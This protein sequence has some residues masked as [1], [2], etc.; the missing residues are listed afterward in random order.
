MQCVHSRAWS[1]VRIKGSTLAAKRGE[2]AKSSN[3]TIF[4]Q[5]ALVLVLQLAGTARRCWRVAL[6]SDL[7]ILCSRAQAQRARAGVPA[8]V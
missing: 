8:L 6:Q 4:G 2:I 7:I 3:I 5:G 1:C